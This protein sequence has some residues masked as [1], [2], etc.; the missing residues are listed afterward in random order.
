MPEQLPLPLPA[1]PA[2][3][4]AD[5]YVSPANRAVIAAVEDWRR[6]PGGTLAVVGPGGAGKSHLAHVFAAA[7]GARVLA[8]PALTGDADTLA[9]GALALDDAEGAPEE[10]LLHL[11]N[12][13][14]AR[15]HPFLLT[16]RTPPARWPVTLPDLKSR[17]STVAL[18]H[19]PPPDDALLTAVLAKL[20]ADRGIAPKPA[21]IPYLVPRIERSFAAAAAV[22]AALDARAMAEGAPLGPRLAA[23]V[24]DKDG[25]GGA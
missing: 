3:G 2:L 7:A 16:A 14:R 10:A 13:M 11:F 19:L 15:G 6:W 8:G 23:R 24:L 5:Y 25:Q 18:A 20:F 21:L 22:V 17:L 9:R 12:L 4:R 1:R